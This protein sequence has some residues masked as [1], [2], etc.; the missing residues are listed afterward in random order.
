M[1]Q[2]L[3]TK[4]KHPIIRHLKCSTAD[5]DDQMNIT[6]RRKNTETLCGVKLYTSDECQNKKKACE[7][8]KSKEDNIDHTGSHT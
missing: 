4:E 5:E 3:A 7:N 8:I 2:S 6:L 1:V